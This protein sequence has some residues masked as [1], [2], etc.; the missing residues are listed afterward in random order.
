LGCGGGFLLDGFPRTLGQATA[1]QAQLQTDGIVLTAVLS[2]EMPIAEIVARL[3]GRRTCRQ[4]KA[5]FHVTQRPPRVL[6][7]CDHCGEPLVQREDDRPEAITTRMEAYA[8]S[9]APLIEF[10]QSLGLLTRVSAAG[11]PEEICSRTLGQ[12]EWRLSVRHGRELA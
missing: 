8:H 9:T 10:Y 6:E 4:C 1:L 5:V 11:S 2:Y 3:S 7:V 12:L